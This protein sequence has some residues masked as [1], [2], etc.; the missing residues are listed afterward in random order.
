MEEGKFK[1]VNR[2]N[3]SE[4]F[5]CEAKESNGAG[6]WGKRG[7]QERIFFNMGKTTY[8]HIDG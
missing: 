7:G 8:F 3:Y 4:E 6:T 5:C 2:I 1:A